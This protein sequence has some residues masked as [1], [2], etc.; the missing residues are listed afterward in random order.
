[1]YFGTATWKLSESIGAGVALEKDA[2]MLVTERFA[3]SLEHVKVM[4]IPPFSKA[5]NGANVPGGGGG[6]AGA[7]PSPIAGPPI[8]DAIMSIPAGGG[9]AGAGAG[10]PRSPRRS[11][12][13]LI[14]PGGGAAGAA[15]PMV[16]AGAGEPPIRSARRSTSAGAGAAASIAGAAAGVAVAAAEVSAL[17]RSE[18]P[19]SELTADEAALRSFLVKAGMRS[20]TPEEIESSLSNDAYSTERCCSSRFIDVE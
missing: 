10:E 3:G 12:M 9:A 16:G 4:L 11:S 5:V 7:A 8:I 13:P 2:S 14:A 17:E 15:A 19:E 20:S 18:P 1:M 6:A